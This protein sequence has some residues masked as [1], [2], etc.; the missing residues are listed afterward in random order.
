MVALG[1][2]DLPGFDRAAYCAPL[3]FDRAREGVD[4]VT[5]AIGRRVAAR[6]PEEASPIIQ[7]CPLMSIDP[8]L[9]VIGWHFILALVK[10]KDARITKVSGAPSRGGG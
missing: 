6:S 8:C 4:F 2:E 10:A 9:M 3:L 5:V 7:R 1:S